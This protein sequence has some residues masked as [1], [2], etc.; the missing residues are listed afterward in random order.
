MKTKKFDIIIA[1]YNRQKSLKK[2]VKSILVCTTIPE[3]IY[4]VDSSDTENEE[5]KNIEKV[6]YIKSTHKNQP[7][8]RYLGYKKSKNEILYYFDDDMEILDKNFF[9]ETLRLFENKDVIAST[10]NNTYNHEFFEKES[11]SILQ[12]IISSIKPLFNIIKLITGNPKLKNGEYWLC[13]IKGKQPLNDEQTN[14][15]WGTGFCV[16]RD[17][18]YKNFNFK[19]FD[20]YEDKLGKGEDGI[21]G[22][23]VSKQGTILYYSKNSLT[24]EDLKNSVY[25]TDYIT[26]GKRVSYSRL[27]LSLEFCRLNNK[28]YRLAYYHYNWYMFWRVLGLK[29]NNSIKFEKKRKDLL[30]GYLIG[31]KKANKKGYKDFFSIKNNWDEVIV[32]D[33]GNYEE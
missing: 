30:E 10:F 28:N 27:Y 26:Y 31:W 13:G 11:K 14:W 2:L 20:L 12:S 21:L 19:L 18:I 23:T 3:N 33:L 24:H 17:K 6:T 32:K 15:F 16:K 29:I 22:Y 8:Q 5:I 7:Y 25:S 1:T 4:V 9:S